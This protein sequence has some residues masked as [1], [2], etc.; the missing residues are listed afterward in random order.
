MIRI[1][2][3]HEFMKNENKNIEMVI[4]FIV[5]KKTDSKEI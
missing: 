4:V 1:K 5:E 2:K 3:I